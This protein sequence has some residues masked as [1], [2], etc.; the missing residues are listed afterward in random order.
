M[1]FSTKTCSA[2]VTKV[3]RDVDRLKRWVCVDV[4]NFK[5][6]KCKVLHLVEGQGNPRH[7]HRLGALRRRTWG[8]WL[9]KNST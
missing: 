4:K 8:C 9:M 7:V 5:E 1:F 2:Q 3:A 6:A